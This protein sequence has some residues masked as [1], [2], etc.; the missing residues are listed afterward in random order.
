MEDNEQTPQRP[1]SGPTGV[2]L[3]NLL[4]E[5]ARLEELIN[6]KF[7][8]VITVMFTDFK[9]STALAETEGD[10]ATRLLIKKHHDILFPI[11]QENRGTL[12]KTMGDGT[13]SWFEKAQDAVRTG[14][15]F[16]GSLKEFNKTR[17]GKIPIVVRVGLNTGSG[18]VEPTDIFGDVVNVAARFESI[19]SPREIY[20][21]E[22]TFHAL[23]DRDEFRCR[24]IKTTELKGKT[25]LH[26]VF[27][28]YWNPDETM[29]AP[30]Q[31][32][33]ERSGGAGEV[34]DPFAAPAQPP[35]SASPRPG[36]PPSGRTGAGSGM[37]SML[38]NPYMMRTTAQPRKPLGGGGQLEREAV[39]RA[40]R[41]IR[42][43]VVRE[44]D[45]HKLLGEG[46]RVLDDIVVEPGGLLVVENAQLFFAE[47]A[48]IVSSGTFRA[49][50]SL[51]TAIDPVSGW[52]NVSLA[53][54]DDR[55]N[56][57]ENCTFRFGK[58]RAHGN[59]PAAVDPGAHR[60]NHTSL[61]GGGL[62][63]LG[64][65]EKSQSVR[66]CV[67]HRCSAH[68]GGGILLLGTSAAVTG[69]TF[70]NCSAKVSGGGVFCIGAS[71]IVRRSNFIGCSA[72]KGGGGAGCRSSNAT[73]DGCLFEKC[74][75]RHIH[76]GGLHIEESSPS[77]TE[78]RFLRCSAGRLGGGIY[79]DEGSAP[80]I[81]K[82]TFTDCLPGNSNIPLG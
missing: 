52:R 2:D 47:N 74:V 71:P 65:S 67:F 8:R 27:K 73:F 11:I 38:R 16:Q 63:V 17:P 61:Y 4:E 29:E 79:A 46:F 62:L 36:G 70:E 50:S 42:S 35:A 30:A 5:R 18:I 76:G 31:P 33:T 12:V 22:S 7:T 56:L 19:A 9:G 53:P 39:G 14:V 10:M 68:E 51:F 78:C 20:I 45:A 37:P 21:S 66:D 13:M 1:A 55:V 82:T 72:D 54:R 3:E 77:V 80:R 28:V 40:A 15:A 43:L 25:G 75:T 49:K 6:R 58:G 64:G 81:S 48:G 32:A 44:G 59:M 23:D 26:K 57:V 60:L 41:E 34:V 24:F 69:G